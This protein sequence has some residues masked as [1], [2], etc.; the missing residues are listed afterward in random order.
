M[1]DTNGIEKRRHPFLWA[2]AGVAILLC[3]G[4]LGLAWVTS[5]LSLV[6]ANNTTVSHSVV[7]EGIGHHQP[8][9]ACGIV[10]ER[11]SPLNAIGEWP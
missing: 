7:V 3:L 11:A 4:I 9:L 5:R 1:T 2:A 6:P 10:Y 8:K